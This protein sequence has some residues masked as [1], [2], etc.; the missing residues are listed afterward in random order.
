MA[1]SKVRGAAKLR[2][3]MKRLPE[4]VRGEI[5]EVLDSAGVKLRD[6]IKARTPRRTGA[7]QAGIS[8]RVYPRT[9]RMQVGFLGSKKTRAALFYGR[10]LEFGRKA[11][12]A[13]AARPNKSGGIS[14]YTVRVKAI[15]PKRFVTGRM[16]DLRSTINKEVKDLWQRSIAKVAEGGID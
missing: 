7:L 3:L 6:A 13:K 11:Q 16:T 10:I 4:S 5:I 15:A 9:M 8:Y 1:R 2:R 14:R 12:I